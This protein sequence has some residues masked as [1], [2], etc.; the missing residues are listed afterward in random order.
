MTSGLQRKDLVILAARPSMGKTSLG[1]NICA[2]AALRNG[3]KVA[4]F[5][6]EMA[7]EQ[8]VRRLL[9]AEARVDQKR[10]AGG[11]LAKSDWPKLEMAARRCARWICGSTTPR[12]SRP[13]SCR[14]RRGASNRSTV[15]IW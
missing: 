14:P 15:S 3:K 1:I 8:L 7:A 2:H 12:A 5:S 4:V 13:S 6:L 9:S 10:I 11:Y